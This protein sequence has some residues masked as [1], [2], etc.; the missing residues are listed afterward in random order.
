MRIP[1]PAAADLRRD[2]ILGLYYRG[3]ELIPLDSSG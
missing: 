2:A 3:A 1:A